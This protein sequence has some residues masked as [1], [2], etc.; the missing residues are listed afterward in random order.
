[1]PGRGGLI[2][3]TAVLGSIGSNAQATIT[4]IEEGTFLYFYEL[5]CFGDA[6]RGCHVLQASASLPQYVPLAYPA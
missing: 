5:L 2:A 3:L 4:A 6:R 1:M